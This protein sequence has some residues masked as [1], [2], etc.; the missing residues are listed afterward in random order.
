MKARKN[1]QTSPFFIDP[2]EKEPSTS[3]EARHQVSGLMRITKLT[4]RSWLLALTN[5]FLL[6]RL[7]WDKGPC[8]QKSQYLE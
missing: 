6:L 4:H 1:Q 8:F 5:L 3:W 2:G 7:R